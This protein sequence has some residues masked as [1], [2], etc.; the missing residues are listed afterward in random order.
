ML[1]FKLNRGHTMLRYLAIAFAA[2]L[3]AGCAT[4]YTYR[5]GVGDYYYGS[6]S[7]DYYDYGYGAPYGSIY[8]YPGRWRGGL[9]FGYGHGGY[10]HPYPYGY[11]YPYGY[12]GGY[13]APYW[14]WHRPY[15]PH[16]P[17]KPPVDDDPPRVTGG[18]LPPNRV[19]G[20]Q[21]PRSP[22]SL[23]PR[24]G[25]RPMLPPSSRGPVRGDRADA[26][27]PRMSRPAPRSVQRP[28]TSSRPSAP[29][30]SA[31]RASRPAPP[32][33]APSFREREP[34]RKRER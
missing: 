11:G 12:Y 23:V 27:P 16:R 17:D 14:W 2:V 31:P 24:N 21:P 4:G 1:Q 25:Q 13:Y 30:R 28:S 19:T 22:A 15:R 8:G 5:D 33:R 6:P 32:A 9:Y 34:D 29:A 3:L 26:S 10:G 20:S 7:V 18:R